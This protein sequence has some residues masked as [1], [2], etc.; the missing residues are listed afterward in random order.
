[1]STVFVG[2]LINTLV[3]V[4]CLF[5]LAKLRAEFEEPVSRGFRWTRRYLYLHLSFCILSIGVAPLVIFADWLIWWALVLMLSPAI[6]SGCV[7]FAYYTLPKGPVV[8]ACC[9]YPRPEHESDES[10]LCPECGNTWWRKFSHNLVLPHDRRGATHLRLFRANR[11][12][13]IGIVPVI[14][15]GMYYGISLGVDWAFY[16]TVPTSVLLGVAKSGEGDEQDRA[17]QE[18]LTGRTLTQAEAD[19]LMSTLVAIRDR[20]AM[21]P[22]VEDELVAAIEAGFFSSS[23]LDDFYSGSIDMELEAV[24]SEDGLFVEPRVHTKEY[25]NTTRLDPEV[26]SPGFTINGGAFHQPVHTL[27]A[28]WFSYSHEDYFIVENGRPF[29][30]REE[31]ERRNYDGYRKHPIDG[32]PPGTHTIV[33]RVHLYVIPRNTSSWGYNFYGPNGTI[34]PHP[35]AIWHETRDL[36]ATFTVPASAR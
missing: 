6:A 5:V 2:G 34:T 28:D 1:M 15:S 8:C 23:A 10:R 20:P 16:K 17:L 36:T 9:G 12:G 13:W 22:N 25:G 35:Q 26:A 29:H 33:A 14:A 30:D 3:A 27:S 11:Y 4:L 18:I 31:P 32:L 7:Y 24:L 21:L 19:S